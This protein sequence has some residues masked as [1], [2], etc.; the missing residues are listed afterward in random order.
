MTRMRIL[1]LLM[2]VL[3]SLMLS[4][5]GSDDDSSQTDGD[6]PDGDTPDGDTTDGDTTDGDTTD[7]DTTDGD[8]T[9]G[10][11]DLAP[12]IVQLNGS[13]EKGPFVLG[14]SIT[15]SPVDALGNPSGQQFTT[16]TIN[17]MGEFSIQFEASGFV[18]LEGS[19]FYYNELTGGLSSANLTLRAY[20]EIVS[21]GVQNAHL[22]LL[23]HLT[24]NRV[25]TLV[26]SGT[27]IADAIAQAEDEL[28]AALPIGPPDFS[29]DDPA[30]EL[31]LQGG[32]TI[33]NAYLFAVSSVLV[34]AA[35]KRTSGSMDANLQEI[36][37]SISADLAPD[38]ELE[39]ARIQELADA[40]VLPREPGFP[41]VLGETLIP[42]IIK[43]NLQARF[44]TLGSN[45]VVPD[46]DR[47]LDSDFDTIVNADDNCW[48]VANEGQD[49]TNDNGFGDACDI[50][51]T[52]PDT[53]LMWQ[54]PSRWYEDFSPVSPGDD[55]TSTTDYCE[56][57]EWGGFDDWEAPY[58]DSLRSLVV[59][60]P[61]SEPDGA[62]GVHNQGCVD[63]DCE[64]DCDGCDS[65]NGP[66]WK[67]GLIGPLAVATCFDNPDVPGGFICLYLDYGDA[68]I[69]AAWWGMAGDDFDQLHARC[70]RNQDN[71]EPVDYDNELVCN[72]GIDEDDDGMTDCDDMG[73]C[74]AAIAETGNCNNL[75]DLE[76]I[77]GLDL[78]ADCIIG[79]GELACREVLSDGCNSCIGGCVMQH[80]V[81]D[82]VREGPDIP[83]ACIDCAR[84]NC[85]KPDCF[86]D[87]ICEPE[88]HCQDGVDNDSDG[89]TDMDDPDCIHLTSG[90]PDGDVDGDIVT[91]GDID[92]DVV[93]DGD[94]DGNVDGDVDDGLP[95]VSPVIDGNTVTFHF[96]SEDSVPEPIK[97]VGN[98]NG[99][100]WD[101][102][103]GLIMNRV[104]ATLWSATT[105]VPCDDYA[106]KFWYNGTWVPDALNPNNDGEP[107]FNSTF[108]VTAGCEVDGDEDGDIDGDIVDGDVIDGDT[109]DGDVVDGDVIDGDTDGDEEVH[110]AWDCSQFNRLFCE[111]D[112]A[113]LLCEDIM[114]QSILAEPDPANPCGF[115]VY[116][117][118][119]GGVTKQLLTDVEDC[120]ITDEPLPGYTEGSCTFTYRSMPI[121][122]IDIQCT[123]E[124]GSASCAIR[125][126]P[127]ACD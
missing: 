92:G 1:L 120:A 10:D 65:V 39:Q 61:A 23:T 100:T 72:D 62:C 95:N 122:G 73:D 22:N 119:D 52:D 44:D 17:D 30:I 13:V 98:F 85:S 15:I 18:S 68:S 19:G 55:G 25:K 99:I 127:E 24:Y 83:Q 114:R 93:I 87:F 2:L 3:F 71:L 48:F 116:R 108:S 86:G 57:M 66:Y 56:A 54:N 8:T 97:V 51:F 11:L 70:V 75:D 43:A 121:N 58:I 6:A 37:N 26:Q 79:E 20:Y 31:T 40:Q 28:V 105:F 106:Y 41:L 29:L 38:G 53:G 14:S 111:V 80:C 12:G 46:L 118:M 113:G 16:Q 78:F 125:L 9:D 74:F 91:D 27:D 101:P 47:I 109:T 110:C 103:R 89:K 69:G 82:C 107:N 34:T 50:V 59:G 84:T 96:I 77:A 32:D 124:D 35:A 112:A 76:G 42:S 102:Q 49:D 7:G 63:D 5:C 36:I 21:D 67:T 123:S 33:E 64:T 45:A 60:C 104:G 81:S 88:F 4:S 115:K 117:T 94:T 90:T 126:E